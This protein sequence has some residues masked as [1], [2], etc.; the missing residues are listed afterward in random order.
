MFHALVQK[1]ERK[2]T[3]NAGVSKKRKYESWA[4]STKTR[5]LSGTNKW[6]QEEVHG[7]HES[8][9]VTGARRTQQ[10]S[11]NTHFAV[12]CFLNWFVCFSFLLFG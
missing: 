1:R 2:K 3:K 8:T 11:Y 9:T 12:S 4:R 10:W 7:T 5:S 6:W